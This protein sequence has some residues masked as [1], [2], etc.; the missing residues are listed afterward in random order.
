MWGG[1]HAKDL[2]CKMAS[3][4]SGAE[5]QYERKFVLVLRAGK[6]NNNNNKGYCEEA[7]AGFEVMFQQQTN[8]NN[9]NNNKKVAL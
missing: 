8:N 6:S 1:G 7:S 4:Y 5:V 2:F 3:S 9:K